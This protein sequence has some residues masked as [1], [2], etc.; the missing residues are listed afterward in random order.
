MI[1]SAA[2]FDVIVD[3]LECALSGSG[4]CVL[5]MHNPIYDRSW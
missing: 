1:G 4:W 2:V 5:V 3:G